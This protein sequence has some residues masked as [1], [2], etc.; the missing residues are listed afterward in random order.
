MFFFQLTKKENFICLTK[1]DFNWLHIILILQL[2]K[3]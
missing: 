3:I 1:Y 2:D